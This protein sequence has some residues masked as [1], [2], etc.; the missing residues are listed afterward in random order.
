MS[1]GEVRT[2]DLYV[3]FSPM[4]EDLKLRHRDTSWLNFTSKFT[5]YEKFPGDLFISL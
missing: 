2:V 4:S 3:E 5:R 1:V